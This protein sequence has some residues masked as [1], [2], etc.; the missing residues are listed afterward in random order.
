MK[1]FIP[2]EEKKDEGRPSK[3]Q[4]SEC[5]FELKTIEL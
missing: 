5:Y 4:R 3:R 2:D 1:E